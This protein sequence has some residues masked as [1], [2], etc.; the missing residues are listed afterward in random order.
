[1]RA[2]RFKNDR[3][4][5]TSEFMSSEIGSASVKPLPDLKFSRI[6]SL[7]WIH[8]QTEWSPEQNGD[9]EVFDQNPVS[10]DW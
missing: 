9:S 4:E 10:S 3:R 5:I 1:V 6:G 2:D 7:R 8:Y